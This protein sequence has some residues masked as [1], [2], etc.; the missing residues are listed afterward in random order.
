M[1]DGFAA[2]VPAELGLKPEI[3]A[4]CYRVESLSAEKLGP[5][6]DQRSRIESIRNC[7]EC[8]INR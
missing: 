6:S 5:E 3:R 2:E 7:C 1:A 8:V 4:I